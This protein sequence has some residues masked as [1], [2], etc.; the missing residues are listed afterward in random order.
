MRPPEPLPVLELAPEEKRGGLEARLEAREARGPRSLAT[1]ATPVL[2]AAQEP[3][4]AP[5]SAAT[6][7]RPAKVALALPRGAT[8]LE[9][10]RMLQSPVSIRAAIVLNEVLGPPLSRRAAPP[11]RPL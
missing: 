2:T 5:G 7:R 1:A 6:P 8:L 3:S 10:G 11:D 9:L 4:V